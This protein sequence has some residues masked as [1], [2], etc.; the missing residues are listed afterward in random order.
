LILVRR[1]AQT[2]GDAGVYL[3]VDAQPMARSRRKRFWRGNFLSR[4]NPR[5]A[6]LFKRFRPIMRE[7][8]GTHAEADQQR[9]RQAS[10]VQ[11]FFARSGQLTVEDFYDRHGRRDVRPSRLDPRA[12]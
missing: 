7:K 8:S 9:D 4:R 2:A 12:P 11:R 3:A 5:W 6:A 10:A 1:V